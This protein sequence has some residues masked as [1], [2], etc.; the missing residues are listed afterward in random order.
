MLAIDNI[1]I[2]WEK[3]LKRLNLLNEYY[4]FEKNTKCE[5]ID[6]QRQLS[7]NAEDSE[8]IYI[9]ARDSLIEQEGY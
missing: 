4:P 1:G 7:E 5:T 2:I 6:F 8:L 9:T 3:I